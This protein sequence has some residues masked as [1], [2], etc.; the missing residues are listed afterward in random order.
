[1]RIPPLLKPGQNQFSAEEANEAR[2]VTKTR[3]IVEARNG[4]STKI[5]K[6]HDNNIKYPS[7]TLLQSVLR[8]CWTDDNYRHL[9]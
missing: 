5:M 7:I 2:I 6:R 4:E 3:W 8:G 1:V 9:H